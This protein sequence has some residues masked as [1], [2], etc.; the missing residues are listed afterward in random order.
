MTPQEAREASD[1]LAP[2]HQR[3]HDHDLRLVQVVY[4]EGQQTR[5]FECSQCGRTWYE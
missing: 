2:P 4:E 1:G 5:E 3:D